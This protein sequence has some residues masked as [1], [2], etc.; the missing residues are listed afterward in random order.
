MAIQAYQ[1]TFFL[2]LAGSDADTMQQTVAIAA[3]AAIEAIRLTRF[4]RNGFREWKG[5]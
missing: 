4:Y 5:A 2:R 3:E 1:L